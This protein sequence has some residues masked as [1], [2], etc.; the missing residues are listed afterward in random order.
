MGD[1]EHTADEEESWFDAGHREREAHYPDVGFALVEIDLMRAPGEALTTLS[2][3]LYLSDLTVPPSSD[4]T[5][6]VVYDADGHA[7]SRADLLDDPGGDD[8]TQADALADALETGDRRERRLALCHLVELAGTA[9]GECLD[10][11]P[12]LTTQLRAVP[13]D[14]Q[15][16]PLRVVATVGSEYPDQIT[17]AIDAVIESLDPVRDPEVQA[18]AIR[19]VDAVSEHDPRVVVDAAPRLAALLEDDPPVAGLLLA[20]LTRIAGVDPDAVAPLVPTLLEFIE[21]DAEQRRIGALSIVGMI[22][23][24]YPNVAES[25]IPVLVELLDAEAYK[26]RGNAAGTLAELADQYPGELRSVVPRCIELLDEDYEKNRYNAT[27]ILA[28]VAKEHPADVEPAVEPL[29][30]VLETEEFAYARSN[31]CW[32][33]GYVAAPAAL[34]ALEERLEDDPDEEVREAAAFAIHEI[35]RG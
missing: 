23:K 11:V 16:M 32:T 35:E 21:D 5:D 17:P 25:S 7:Y 26:V 22:A 27:S 19:V 9:P 2:R 12:L 6:Y 14:V 29:I 8:A 18:D 3:T 4:L 31:A 34:E 33:L 28:R 10:L 20:A 30:E 13:P 1:G 15:A 24:E